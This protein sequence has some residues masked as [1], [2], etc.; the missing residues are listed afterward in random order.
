MGHKK[1]IEVISGVSNGGDE[2]LAM[3]RPYTMR[4]RVRGTA[5]LLLH[6]WNCESVREKA[7]AKKGSKQKKMDDV[8]SYVYRNEA[9]EICLPG[10]YLKGSLCDSRNGAAKYRQDP[11]SPRKCAIDLYRA[12]VVVTTE[13]AQVIPVGKDA[14]ATAWDY[15]DTRRVV[16]Q[17][18]GITRQRPAFSTGWTAEF[19]LLVLTPELICADDL[20]ATLCDGGR[21]VGLGDFRP[22]YGRF[23][24]EHAEKLE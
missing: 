24:V 23:V 21:L 3:A 19:D 1:A 16:V 2:V 11:R 17:R 14:P 20:H 6:A 5:P 10:C 12:G 18:Q 4:V 7:E 22:T 13:L 15:L 9:G 8:A